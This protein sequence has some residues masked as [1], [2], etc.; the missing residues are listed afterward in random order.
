MKSFLLSGF[1]GLS[2]ACIG[3]CADVPPTAS[4]PV[5]VLTSQNGLRAEVDR[6]PPASDGTISFVVRVKGNSL[7]LSAY[8]GSV[9]FAPGVFEL[10]S[11]ET[12]QDMS[13]EVRI[14]NPAAF[15]EGRIRFAA[16]SSDSLAAD[17]LG[18]EAFRFTVRVVSSRAD[19]QVAASLDTASAA[20]GS[21]LMLRAGSGTA[22]FS[23]A[24]PSS[25]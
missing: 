9:N 13:G 12:P 16:M 19:A 5:Q 15:A 18:V 1:A 23:L 14:V 24:Q 11:T 7:S 8:Q 6:Q 2:A 3:A 25:R 22:G 10:V 17:P 21:A 20:D 4:A